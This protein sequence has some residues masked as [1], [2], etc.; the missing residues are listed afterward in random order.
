[1][2]ISQTSSATLQPSVDIA[3]V[4]AKAKPQA[5]SSGSSP[6]EKPSELKSFTYG[7]LGLDH[8]EVQAAETDSSYSAGKWLGAAAKVGAIISLLA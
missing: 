1:M 3:Q 4:A 5:P 8:P 7:A 2:G 6:A